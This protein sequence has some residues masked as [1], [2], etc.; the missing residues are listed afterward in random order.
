MPRSSHAE[1]DLPADR[2]DPIDLLE[3]SNRGRLP[4]LVPVRYAWMLESDFAF[5]RGSPVVM[6][7]DLARTPQTGINVQACG[8]AHLLNFGAYA[9]PDRRLTFDV[10]DFDETLP[11]PW[12]WDVK[13]LA[14]SCAVA[15]RVVGRG[16]R[17]CECRARR[18]RLGYAVE[19]ARLVPLST[20]EIHYAH[21]DV[22]L[23]VLEATDPVDANELRVLAASSRSH[24]T[25]Q[26]FTKLTR[27]V[28]GRRRIV[29]RPPLI[30]R[31]D[32]DSASRRRSTSSTGG[33]ASRCPTT[34]AGSSSSTTSATSRRRSSVSAASARVAPSSCSKGGVRSIRCSCR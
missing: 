8:D 10:N 34:A 5:L 20:L 7:W 32:P 16:R 19:M 26:A 25:E 13:R 28:D 33:T 30:V 18:P 27:D 17:R 9:T 14:A 22:D 2:P 31:F 11:A 23:A 15:A 4:D 3:Q 21:T 6:T 24:T 29:E 12:E 1:L